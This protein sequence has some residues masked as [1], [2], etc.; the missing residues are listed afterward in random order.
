MT[1]EKKI[2]KSFQ[3]VRKEIDLFKYDTYNNLRFLNV[4]VKEQAIRIRELERR[5][6]QVERL[7]LR[8]VKNGF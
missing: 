4:K 8:V 5:L 2:K 1:N 6:A 3:N 7:S